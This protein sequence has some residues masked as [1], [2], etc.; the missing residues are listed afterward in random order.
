ML[1][2]CVTCGGETQREHALPIV[3]ASV[4]EAVVD[5]D[6]VDEPVPI[7]VCPL[8]P[9]TVGE[10]CATVNALVCEYGTASSPSCD[11]LYACLPPDKCDEQPPV[12][13]QIGTTKTCPTSMPGCLSSFD[14]AR[15]AGACDAFAPCTY[16]AGVCD[17]AGSLGWECWPDPV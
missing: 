10:R 1:L 4:A 7:T 15:D 11:A 9:P 13:Q 16:A 8:A 2:A 6:V 17:C 14:E 3:D 5:L 12:W